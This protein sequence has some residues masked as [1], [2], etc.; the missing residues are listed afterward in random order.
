MGF[1]TEPPSASDSGRGKD[2]DEG[3]YLVF[4]GLVFPD[5]GIGTR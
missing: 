2:L 3:V 4:E 5:V 1:V